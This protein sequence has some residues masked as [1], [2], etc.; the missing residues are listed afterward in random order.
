MSVRKIIR[1]P[2]MQYAVNFFF[3]FAVLTVCRIVFFIANKTY[4]S[5]IELSH[6]LTLMYGGMKFD[7]AAIIYLTGISFAMMILP[8]KFVFNDTYRKI[9]KYFF[10][11]PFSI[12]VCANIFDAAYFGFN[13]RRTNFS[14]FNEFSNENNLFG[15]FAKGLVDFWPLTLTAILLVFIVVRFYY[16]P[17]TKGDEYSIKKYPLKILPATLLCIYFFL[18][19]VRGSFFIDA[20][21]RPMNMNN[22]NEYIRKS[23]ES[24]IVLN[25]PYCI[26]RTMGDVAFT[27]PNYFSDEEMVAIYN[28][29]HRP[30]P[31]D[32]FK[33]MNVV[34]LILESFGREYSGFLN[35]T[36]GYTPF[37]D[38]LYNEGLTFKTAFATGRKSIDAMP[39]ILAGIPFLT[40]H[41][42]MSMYS[43]N[44]VNSLASLL[45]QKGYYSAFYHG[46]PNGSMGFLNFA[47]LSGFQDYY[48]MTEYCNDT[49]FNG[50]DD[51]DG[52]WAIWDEEF[53]QYYAKSLGTI[54]QPFVTVCFTASS[55]NPFRLPE[56]YRDT[57][58]EGPMPI[59]KC[60]QYTDN[61]IRLFFNKMQ[62]YPWFENTLF[63]ITADHTNQIISPR[64][65][66][67]RNLFAVPI[68]FY[69]PGSNLKKVSDKLFCHT[70]I[71][72][73]ILD[74]MNFD[75]PFIA[76]GNSYFNE[77]DTA[78]Y[79]VN[80]NTPL[81]QI[82]KG[83]FFLQ[84]DGTKETGLFK[85]AEDT[86]LTDNLAGQYPEY[87]EEML[88]ILKAEIQ[89]YHTR[90]IENNLTVKE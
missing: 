89:Q 79:V 46:A 64:Y 32:E 21:H 24:A 83:E 14:F 22:A 36:K 11:I 86:L 28:P 12:G 52:H 18:A 90:M 80:F 87:E 70:D 58:T 43:N 78:G 27:N 48:G 45:G 35:G 73:T 15:I 84:F 29:E 5:D 30:K 75:Q 51:F 50:K 85:P 59:T 63:V 68:L 47:K 38:S 57:F 56:K 82:E 76:F 13:G 44:K 74:Y 23:N 8:F 16:N 31:A 67:D 71:T 4:Y 39:S 40:D 49:S 66:T 65:S 20:D 53:L 77:Q 1:H 19:V 55:H 61:A 7:F 17:E 10:I 6:L 88:R 62:Q 42:F 34:V 3:A 72:P 33:E 26:L 60:V 9:A 2:I 81:Y 41:F 25:T 54:P 69:H 37:L